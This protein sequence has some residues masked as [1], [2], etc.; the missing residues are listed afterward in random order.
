MC[1]DFILSLACWPVLLTPCTAFQFLSD[2]KAQRQ[3]WRFVV[4]QV[5]CEHVVVFVWRTAAISALHLCPFI[6][7]FLANYRKLFK[8]PSS[9]YSLWNSTFFSPNETGI[10]ML[11]PLQYMSPQEGI[12]YLGTVNFTEMWLHAGKTHGF[13]RFPIV[14]ESVSFYT[15]HGW[16][17][18]VFGLFHSFLIGKSDFKRVHLDYL[19]EK[20]SGNNIML[21]RLLNLLFTHEFLDYFE[22]Q[23]ADIACTYFVVSIQVKGAKLIKVKENPSVICD[24]CIFW[25]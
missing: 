16:I 5:I 12:N 11:S 10:L 2:K 4:L 18:G 1:V 13:I 6:S 14:M 25:L 19:M 23:T 9:F 22:S 24:V 8:F 21:H 17:A 7:F 15:M 20:D 3:Q